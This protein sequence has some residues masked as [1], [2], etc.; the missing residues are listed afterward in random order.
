MNEEKLYFRVTEASWSPPYKFKIIK[1]TEIRDSW[2]CERDAVDSFENSLKKQLEY[3]LERL[4]EDREKLID[5][6]NWK[7]ELYGE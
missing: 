5:F 4:V 2:A 1:S 3:T 6:K 7:S